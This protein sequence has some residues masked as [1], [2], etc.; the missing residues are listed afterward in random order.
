MNIRSVSQ[1]HLQS[2]LRFI[3]GSRVRHRT[4][5][6]RVGTTNLHPAPQ[7]RLSRLLQKSPAGIAQRL[8]YNRPCNL[9]WFNRKWSWRLLRIMQVIPLQD[10]LLLL[11]NLRIQALLPLRYVFIV[12]LTRRFCFF[13]FYQATRVIVDCRLLY[14]EWT[15]GV[16][17]IRFLCKG[18]LNI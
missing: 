11:R 1:R 18:I 9:L 6:S 16:F 10:A 7:L 15:V 3:L 14:T 2:H 13:F 12:L 8:L 17:L 4:M 5:T